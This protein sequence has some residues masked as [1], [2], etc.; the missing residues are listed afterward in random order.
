MRLGL[1]QAAYRWVS[2]PS[3]RIGL[4][5]YGFRGMP[6]P[7]GTS[8][9]GPVAL[10]DNFEW[11]IARCE[12]WQFDNLYMA[13]IWFNDQKEARRAG[14]KLA[15]KGIEWIG[16]LSG[17][18]A[19]EPKEWPRELEN[20]ERAMAL[21]AAGGVRL[22]AIVNADPPGPPGQPTPNG[23]LR[24]GHFSREIP[25]AR[26]IENM[27]QNLSELVRVAERHGIV[28]AF[29]N[30]MDYRISEI[31]QVVRGINSPWLQINYDFA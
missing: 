25:M 13:T 19:V 28:M 31:V 10:E 12:E 27:V 24:F 4:P 9:T 5:Q 20:S 23:G 29:E 30:H 17:A 21:M 3:L 16:S 14:A 22:S 8:T 1:S 7:Y 6:Y 11:W 15:A 2:Y 18:W 26:Q